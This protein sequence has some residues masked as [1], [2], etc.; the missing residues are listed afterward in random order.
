MGEHQELAAD[1]KMIE[2]LAEEARAYVARCHDAGIVHEAEHLNNLQKMTSVVV[3]IKELAAAMGAKLTAT[4]VKNESAFKWV[5]GEERRLTLHPI[6]H[7]D[8]W[9]FCKKMEG[10]RWTAQEVDLTRDKKDWS[11]MTA[12]QK[13]FVKM[14]LAFFATIDIDVLKNLGENFG[15]EID[16]IEAQLTIVAQKD[17]ERVH[18]ESYGLQILS[19]MEGEEFENV[20]NAA[21]TMPI[22]TRMR[23]WVLRWFDRRFDIGD[24]LVAFAVV[25]GVLFSASF[26]ALQ[27]LRELNLLPG[28][29]DFNSFIVRDEGVHTLFTCLLVRK[30][31]RVK[32]SQARVEDIFGSVI[33]VLDDFVAEALPLN[34]I[35]MNAML[36]KEYV[37]FQADCVLIEMEYA[38]MYGI[39]N[40]FKFMDKMSLNGSVKTN[41]FEAR[42]T[43][44][45][46]V[47]R[48]GQATLG[49]DETPIDD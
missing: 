3:V 35:G 16:C 6:V 40:P 46:C 2:A 21:R 11:Q 44:Y 17:Q 43:Q 19:V 20:L 41:F 36:M 9:A 1:L 8:I 38:P 49:M 22:I 13:L 27:W 10:L 4:D 32:P 45:S 34:L 31:L 39:K 28:I 48:T 15:K 47:T 7:D 29:T 26:S 37:R 33:E 30:Y 42:P 24:R 25:E 23:D 5:A 12:N 18:V 14:N